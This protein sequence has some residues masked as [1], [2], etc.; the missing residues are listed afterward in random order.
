M[1]KV[2]M[3]TEKQTIS[4]KRVLIAHI[5]LQIFIYVLSF[6]TLNEYSLGAIEI[7]SIFLILI[8]NFII[9]T[10]ILLNDKSSSTIYYYCAV[11]TIISFFIIFDINYLRLFKIVST[12]LYVILMV[13]FVMLD[14]TMKIITQRISK[15][16]FY[17]YI[18]I[19]LWT[20]GVSLGILNNRAYLIVSHITLSIISI[21]PILFILTNLKKINRYG[22]HLFPS[23][24]LVAIINIIFLLSIFFIPSKSRSSNNHDIYL[25]FHVLEFIL[26]YFILSSLNLF[27]YLRER[28]DKFN[29]KNII[30]LILGYIYFF[31]SKDSFVI[32]LFWIISFLIIFKEHQILEYYIKQTVNIKN[33]YNSEIQNT[34]VI[35]NMI[36]KNNMDIQIEK[37]YN[38]QVAEFLHNETL[39]DAIYIKK[40]LSDY[41]KIPE[42]DKIFEV[43]DKIINNT[44]GRISLYKPHINYE[45]SISENYY[46]LIK[47]LKNRF[48]NDN[49][50]LDFTCDDKLFLSSPY[51]VVVYRMIHELVTNIFKHSK[52]EYSTIELSVEKNMIILNVINYGDYLDI[53]F[54]NNDSLGLKIIERETER[55]NGTLNISSTLDLDSIDNKTVEENSTVNIKITL[56]IKGEITYEYFINR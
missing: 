6:K 32:N 31:Y 9:Y 50:L 21:Y 29:Y 8:Y 38:E 16:L 37:L 54:N 15:N 36:Y 55:F 30:Y 53:N 1:D 3:E 56:P 7:I 19:F 40:L 49:I 28:R 43:I 34:D 48:N 45:I 42:D 24:V 4:K 35:Q 41:Y 33:L 27:K 12:Y 18:I 47:S 2:S 46:N 14:V 25:Y 13:L 22:R 11:T 20:V 17:K 23:I 26:T 5:I 52:G 51:D 10:V 44:R 39:Q